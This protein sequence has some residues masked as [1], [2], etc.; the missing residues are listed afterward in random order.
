MRAKASHKH[1]SFFL[2]WYFSLK[3]KR[4]IGEVNI[5]FI[6]FTG[7]M[8]FILSVVSLAALSASGGIN[9]DNQVTDARRVAL[10]RGLLPY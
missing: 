6:V 4:S 5:E 1:N 8:M 10:L 3:R 7:I 2:G 9:D